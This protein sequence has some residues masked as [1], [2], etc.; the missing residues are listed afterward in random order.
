MVSVL[1]L[2]IFF[3]NIQK[4]YFDRFLLD[5]IT[6]ARDSNG[7]SVSW[8]LCHLAIDDA[9]VFTVEGV[10]LEHIIQSDNIMEER[11]NADDFVLNWN[12]TW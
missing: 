11:Q 5:D 6:L 7:F 4:N 10:T 1:F 3:I 9:E 12:Q 2:Y 8:N